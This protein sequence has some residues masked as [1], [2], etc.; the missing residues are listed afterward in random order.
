[1]GDI[2]C[3][4]QPGSPFAMK[5]IVRFS[6]NRYGIFAGG[7]ALGALIDYLITL[8]GAR[9]AGLPASLA[10]GFAMLIS[11]TAVFFWHETVTFAAAG[12][13]GRLRRYLAFMG[14]SLVVYLLR[15]VLLEIFRHFGMA[16]PLALAVAILIASVINYLISAAVIFRGSQ[17]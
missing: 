5:V 17:P 14:W 6:V 13:P 10:L 7:A 12:Q 16:L 3:E 11:A 1:M 8:G 9:L 4:D 15:A 2:P